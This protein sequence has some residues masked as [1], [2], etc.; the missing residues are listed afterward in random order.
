M[1][2]CIF[3]KIASKE[4]AKEFVY[5]DEDIMVFD[6]IN[7]VKSVHVLVVPKKHMKDLLQLEDDTLKVKILNTI[8]KIAK[9]KSLEDKGFRVV[10]NGGGAQAID[11]LHLHLMGPMG[12]K[13]GWSF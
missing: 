1:N 9:E 10:A 12:E 5:E 11:H 13:A 6:D 3:C 4:V 7:P 8:Q 2:E